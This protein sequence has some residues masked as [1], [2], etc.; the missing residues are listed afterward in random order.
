MWRSCWARVLVWFVALAGLGLYAVAQESTG[1]IYGRALDEKGDAVPGATATLIGD[2]AP[3]STV[4]DGNGNFRFLK[5]PPG[6]YKVTVA[7][8]GFASLERDGVIVTLGRNTS[9]EARLK[10]SAVA[11]TVTVSGTTPLIDTRKVQTGATFA[12]EELNDIPTSRDIYAL[13]QQVPGV[14]LDSVNVAGAAS[15][16]AG[17]PDFSTKGS[18]GVTYSLDGATVTDNSYGTF[19]GGQARQ[20]GGTPM[21]FDF[22]SFD[23][24]EVATGGSLLELQTPGVT[25]NVVTKRGTNEFKGSAR[26]FYVADRWQSSNLPQEAIDQG[27]QTDSTRFIREYGAELGGPL[28]KDKV[29]IWGAGSRQDIGLNLTGTDPTGN[30]IT[31]DTKIQPWTAKINAQVSPENALSFYYQYSKRFERGVGNASNRPPE[32]REVLDIPT[33]FFKLEDNHVFSP[34]L[35]ASVFV[36]YQNP[37]Y[38]D[39]PQ[40]P[41]NVQTVF[42]DDIYHGSWLSYVTHNPQ[43]QANATVSKFFNTGKVNHELKASFNYRRQ[44]NDSASA[45]PGDQIFGSEFSTY[46]LAAVTRGVRAIYK[47]VYYTGTIGDTLTADRL[48]V[49]AGVRYD[50]QQGKNLASFAPENPTFPELLPAVQYGGDVGT[51]FNYKNWQPRISATYAAG[52]K[53]KTLLRASY[54]RFADQLGFLPF[55]LNGLPE[56]SGAYYYWTDANHDHHVDPGEIDFASGIQSYYN[57]S[58]FTAG[59]SPN[60]LAPN[61]KTPV[62]DE[63]TFGVDHQLFDDFAVSATYT[64]RHAKDFQARVPLGSTPDTWAPAGFAQGSATAGN[65]FNLNFDVPFYSLT[66]ENPPTGDLFLNR[67]GATTNYHGIEFSAVKR[68]SN[69]WLARA[70]F[71]WNS[72]KQNIPPEAILDPNNQWLLAGQNEDGGTV[73]GY[74]G[75]STLWIN[76]HW[77]F[78]VSALYQLPLGINV[79]ANFFGREGYPQSYYI[80]SRIDDAYRQRVLRRNL[81][82]KIDQFRLDNVYELDLRLEK[83]FNV[84]QLGLSLIAECFNV[85]NNDTVLQRESRV[86]DWNFNADPG[87]EFTK[88]SL[89]NQIIETQSPR[90]LRLGA[91][92][93]F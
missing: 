17:G 42:Y 66:L 36:S 47:T 46:A 29:W 76:A 8:P 78:N 72:W 21:Y 50:V 70:S 44:V 90:I 84:G 51:P 13:M 71:G 82:G 41:T 4:S 81:V 16:R 12:K 56:I 91:R 28:I 3:R 32:T 15:G 68:L 31:S 52:K 19:N 73:V 49:N 53:R 87:H 54:A 45:W 30:R 9:V 92:I 10:V 7:M 86:G 33:H 85:T 24:V 18:G 62:T 58:P 40:G 35:V 27:F 60:A 23:Q 69:R 20:N 93:T 39:L 77:Q 25:I 1:N 38:F 59:K 5:V 22:E 80:R 14:Q 55:Q 2:R 83:T 64:Y 67:P 79:G 57:V 63:L 43:Y 34:D 11:E 48:T 65:G 74:S 61:F 37:R 88:Y 75:K 6:R 26:Y 89:F